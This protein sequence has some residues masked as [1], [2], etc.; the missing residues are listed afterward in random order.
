MI[1]V[2]TDVVVAVVDA[3][4]TATLVAATVME[5]TV[6]VLLVAVAAD[7]VLL[8]VDTVVLRAATAVV[9]VVLKAAAAVGTVAALKAD[10]E[11]VV[12][13]KMTKTKKSRKALFFIRFLFSL[14]S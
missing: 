1:A 10:K 13:E 7:V 3:A 5:A 4:E 8:A 2:A 9:T 6:V 12:S 14:I 11:L